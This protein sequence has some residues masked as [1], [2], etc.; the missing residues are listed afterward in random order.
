MG[1]AIGRALASADS[2]S[3]IG[4][5]SP[6]EDFSAAITLANLDLTTFTGDYAGRRA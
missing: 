4:S 1:A 3:I 6:T 5:V 2:L